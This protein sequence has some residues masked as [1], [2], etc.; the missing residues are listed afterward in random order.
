MRHLAEGLASGSA[1]PGIA[2]S[3]H[4]EAMTLPLSL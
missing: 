2:L 4:K 3:I 1:R